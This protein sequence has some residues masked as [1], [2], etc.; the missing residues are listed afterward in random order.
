MCLIKEVQFFLVLQEANRKPAASIHPI[1]PSLM[2]T[3]AQ[4]KCSCAASLTHVYPHAH[5]PPLPSQQVLL[6]MPGLEESRVIPPLDE[7][8]AIEHAVVS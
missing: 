3:Q 2:H 5:L 1:S 8:G 7:E 6:I 4:T